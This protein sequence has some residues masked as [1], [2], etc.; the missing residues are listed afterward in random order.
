MQALTFSDDLIFASNFFFIEKLKNTSAR[1]KEKT[2]IIHLFIKT[3]LSLM[4]GLILSP[5]GVLSFAERTTP[6]ESG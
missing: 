4:T 2:N 1:D 6:C 3:L 5:C